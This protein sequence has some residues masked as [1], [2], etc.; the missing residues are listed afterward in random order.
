MIYCLIC[1]TCLP[2]EPPTPRKR[3]APLPV[4]HGKKI[5]YTEDKPSEV[6]TGPSLPSIEG[7]YTLTDIMELDSLKV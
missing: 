1:N 2:I 7:G 6:L 5:R 4:R 3:S